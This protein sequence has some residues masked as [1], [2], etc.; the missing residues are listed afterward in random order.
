MRRMFL[1]AALAAGIFAA[2]AAARQ[3]G[4]AAERARELAARMSKK[5]HQVKEKYGV[6]VEKFKEIRS[7]PAVRS[8][9]REYGGSYEAE[10]GFRLRL[11]V[12]AGGGV[13]GEGT[14]GSFDGSRRARNFRLRDA[15]V[16]GALLTGTKVFD[17]GSSEKLEGVFINKTDRV[18]PDDPGTTVFGLGVIYDP[19]LVAEGYTVSRLFYQKK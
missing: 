18:R 11:S 1:A 9:P 12:G 10:G 14:D 5:K 7:E 17:D 13:E 4:A 19:P 16:E 3:S 2:P 15:R 6:R 8:D